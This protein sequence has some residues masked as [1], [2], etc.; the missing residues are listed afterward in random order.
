MD[1]SPYGAILLCC[2]LASAELCCVIF[3]YIPPTPTFASL[4]RL[5]LSFII[6][7]LLLISLVYFVQF[8]AIAIVLKRRQFH[9]D[10]R[11]FLP[12]QCRHCAKTLGV[13]SSDN[14]RDNESADDD[15]WKNTVPAPDQ[16]E[17]VSHN[18]DT[19]SMPYLMIPE[20]ALP[21]WAR[22]E[23]E[24]EPSC[25]SR[26]ILNPSLSLPD[27]STLA[28]KSVNDNVCQKRGTVHVAR[29]EQVPSISTDSRHRG[30]F[31]KPDRSLLVVFNLLGI[32]SVLNIPMQLLLV[33][34]CL[35]DVELSGMAQ[36]STI[37]RLVLHLS[38][39]TLIV[40]AL[41]F[42]N[43]YHDAAFRDEAVTSRFFGII[44]AFCFWVCATKL[45]GP[46]SD[47]LN[48]AKDPCRELSG[49]LQKFLIIH[50]NIF[51]KIEAECGIIG[52]GIIWEMWKSVIPHH[53][54]NVDA[55]KAKFVPFFKGQVSP[56]WT[57]WKSWTRN[58]RSIRR[59]IDKGYI[60]QSHGPEGLH[61]IQPSRRHSSLP[62]V[63]MLF[64]SFIFG[65]ILMTVTLVLPH[66]TVHSTVYVV[67]CLKTACVTPL[68]GLIFYQSF[69]TNASRTLRV[70]D[71]LPQ[72]YDTLQGHEVILVVSCSSSFL[73]S[74]F[75]IGSAIAAIT[76]TPHLSHDELILACYS[77][78]YGFF[79]IFHLWVT[80]RFLLVVQRQVLRGPAVVK[81]T[82]VCLIYVVLV[83]GMIWF[84]GVIDIHNSEGHE[85]KIYY[86]QPMGKFL[87]EIFDPLVCLFPLHAAIIAYETYKT[88]K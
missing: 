35:E 57:I 30:L 15:G 51:S 27:L 34:K 67:W 7:R 40:C 82:K 29:E 38:F 1:R 70:N 62:L 48:A 22:Y 46:I 3:P 64:A 69:L 59:R 49:S 11:V 23:N 31:T 75:R 12:L 14:H 71:Y 76:Y 39:I 60:Q 84:V 21:I 74:L 53:F 50:N 13:L 86:G 52:A 79:V 66:V 47:S 42:F 80:T 18:E 77:I 87:R 17:G 58:F 55:G 26:F 68:I 88:I 45:V 28:Y 32:V 8:H 2:L 16:T 25:S 33:V 41:I 83:N 63:L 43:T 44:F 72:R 5:E 78:V 56:S 73:L 65:L 54:L 20:N 6:T 19:E 10:Q 9:R 85:L 4:A 36:T 37:V 61:Q 81:W 24:C